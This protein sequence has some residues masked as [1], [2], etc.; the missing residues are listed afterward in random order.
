VRTDGAQFRYD[1]AV[2]KEVT[3]ATN[4]L[5]EELEPGLRYRVEHAARSRETSVRDW[6]EE[7]I[8][9]ELEREELDDAMTRLSAPS[10]TRDWDSD[11]D[12]IYDELKS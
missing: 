6:V 4:S 5:I 3:V 1:E 11:D 8:R 10:F 7:A 2:D 12:A 9:R